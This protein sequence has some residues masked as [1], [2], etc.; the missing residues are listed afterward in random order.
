ML[1]IDPG[2]A[3]ARW[4]LGL[5]QGFEGDF[6]G[7]LMTLEAIVR[8][9]PRHEG[10]LYDLAMTEMMLGM[11]DEAKHHFMALLSINPTHENA[12]RQLAFFS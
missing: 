11:N 9:F 4:Q 1:D 10:A 7:S 5:I 8:D 3:N 12:Q 6:D 2:H